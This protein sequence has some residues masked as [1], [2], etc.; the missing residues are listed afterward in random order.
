MILLLN[1]AFGIGKTTVARLLVARM[2]RAM[3]FDPEWIGI[4]LQR[5]TRVEDF[6]DL[7]LWRWLTIA[8]LRIARVFR[9]N[10]I[11]PMAISNPDYLDEIRNALKPRV[12]HVCLVAPVDEVHAR[13][14]Q[15]GDAGEWE[16]R[17]ASECCTVH[18]GAEFAAQIDARR[19]PTEIADEL[20]RL[21]A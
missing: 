12:V 18:G 19:A 21:L 9:R 6:Q 5:V 14:R 13:L 3:L 1:G 16:F 17:R 15:R 10:V 20:L 2:E 7:R 8:G 4:A 11:V